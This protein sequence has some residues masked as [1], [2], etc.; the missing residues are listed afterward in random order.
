[1][2]R[3]FLPLVYGPLILTGSFLIVSEASWAGPA[4]APSATAQ[5]LKPSNGWY[6][7]AGVGGA[8]ATSPTTSYSESGALLGLDYSFSTSGHA[9]LG[10]GVATEV[11]LGYGFANHLR[12]ELSYVFSRPSLG[13]AATSGR[14]QIVGLDLPFDGVT[15]ASGSVNTNSIF[16]N[17][18]YDLPTGSRFRPYVGAGIGWTNVSVP[19]LRFQG[20]VLS[21]GLS[22]PLG[23]QVGGGNASA[24]GYQAK[25]GISYLASRATD[26]YVEGTYQGNTAVSMVGIEVGAIHQFGVRAGVRYRFGG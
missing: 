6:G 18:Y 13:E 21:F 15:R 25:V 2:K 9:S 8:W 19:A 7:N 12:S 11:G 5:V 3:G 22:E 26:V 10:G 23:A 16:L 14:F 17:G 20:S 24:F 4:G 1:M